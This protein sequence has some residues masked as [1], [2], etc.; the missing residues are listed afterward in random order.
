MKILAIA[1]LLGGMLSPAQAEEPVN[2]TPPDDFDMRNEA[3]YQFAMTYKSECAATT[4]GEKTYPDV[5]ISTDQVSVTASTALAGAIASVKYRD[6]EYIGSGGHGAAFQWAIRPY[7]RPTG[8]PD[9]VPPGPTECYNPTQA[10]SQ[11][12]DDEKE[13]PF[14]GPSTSRLSLFE[15]TSK[16]SYIATSRLAMYVPASQRSKFPEAPCTGSDYQDL[17]PVEGEDPNPMS[18]GQSRY[19]LSP[20]VSVNGNVIKL[21]AGLH[22]EGDEPE[23]NLGEIHSTIVAY[24]Q[25]DFTKEYSYVDRRLVPF[26]RTNWDHKKSPS[27]RCTENGTHCMGMFLK[28]STTRGDAYVYL[29]SRAPDEYTAWGGSYTIEAT[30]VSTTRERHLDM[31]AYAVVG[32]LQKVTDTFDRLLGP[33]R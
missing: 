5:T 13:P 7:V 2:C 21:H 3:H 8:A 6:K 23:A 33:V 16:T 32:D 19:W 18:T 9:T 25:R 4:N 28:N 17:T 12:D 20:D 26:D 14:H 24:T 22:V 11:K 29:E 10:G 27:L 15:K 31:S 1:A 30:F